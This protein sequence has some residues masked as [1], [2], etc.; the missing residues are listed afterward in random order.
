MVKKAW[1]ISVEGSQVH[2]LVQKCQSVQREFKD[3][4][5]KF[6]GIAKDRIWEIEQKLLMIQ[7]AD[8][9]QENLELEASLYM[10]LNQWL[11]REELKWKQKSRELW[12]KEGDSNSK[13]FHAST[14]IFRRRN[15]ISEIKL[16]S[17]QWI[18]TR[19]DIEQYF[20]SKFQM[21][22]NSSLP[23]IPEDINELLSPCI[24]EA[25][26]AEF[27]NIPEPLEIKKAVWEMHPLKAPGPNGLPGLFFKHYWEI[28]GPQIISAVQDFFSAW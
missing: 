18:H 13:F 26:N 25:E 7:D 27:S 28:V 3:W 24:S 10:E 16:D 4:N 23:Q 21:L 11:E 5:K 2:R 14:L 19:E 1:L 9:T 17:G 12:L 22:Y 6:F 8:P 20:T 15:F